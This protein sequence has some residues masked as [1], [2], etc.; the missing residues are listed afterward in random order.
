MTDAG[1]DLRANVFE[2]R[3]PPVGAE[4]LRAASKHLTR[5]RVMAFV[6]GVV[7]LLGTIAL[8]VKYSSSTKLEPLTGIL[9]VAHGYLYLVYVIATAMLGFRLRWPLGRYVL[10]MLAGTIPTMSFV[11]EHYVTRAAR[12]AAQRDPATGGQPP[13]QPAPVQQTPAQPTPLSD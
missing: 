10:V 5:Y 3:Q 7:L 8:I 2:V 9:W 6:T 11:A 4:R 1:F 12:A 13:V